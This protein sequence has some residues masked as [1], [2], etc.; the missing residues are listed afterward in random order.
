MSGPR[1]NCVA[2]RVGG[3][4]RDRPRQAAHP[5]RGMCSLTSLSSRV[6]LF[7]DRLRHGHGC[8][9]RED[10]DVERRVET[11]AM[12]AAMKK[13]RIYHDFGTVRQ[14]LVLE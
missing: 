12:H 14:K 3:G 10:M 11:I 7:W 13:L 2:A 9:S 6:P 8:S 4:E 5:L 1:D